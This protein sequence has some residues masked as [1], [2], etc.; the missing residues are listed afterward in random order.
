MKENLSS[1]IFV[2]Q[3]IK[4]GL[5]IAFDP[6]KDVVQLSE[7]AIAAADFVK[8]GNDLAPELPPGLVQSRSS[9]VVAQ[10]I[11]PVEGLYEIDQCGLL[12]QGEV[13]SRTAI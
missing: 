4:F 10:Q 13:P 8:S 5:G 11:S 3:L 7:C 6:L 9:R 2:E 1:H 12:R